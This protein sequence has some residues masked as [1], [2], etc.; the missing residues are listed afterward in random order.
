MEKAIGIIYD[1]L[2]FILPRVALE[3]ARG[4]QDE[5]KAKVLSVWISFQAL[6]TS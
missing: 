1:I 6:I 3:C 5:I 4:I 2:S